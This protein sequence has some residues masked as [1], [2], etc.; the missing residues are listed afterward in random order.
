MRTIHFLGLGGICLILC[1]P[2]I[3]APDDREQ[4]LRDQV[5][6]A[7]SRDKAATA[8]RRYF[9][10]LGRAGL[11]E[12]LTDKDTA[13]ALHAAWEVHKKP[14]K[15]AKLIDNR[16]DHIYDR[17]ELS[18]FVAFLK[19]RTKAP[20]PDWWT[21]AIAEVE[22]FPGRHHGFPWKNTVPK[23]RKTK[24]GLYVPD[25]VKLEEDGGMLVYTAGDR[26][27][28]FQ[29]SAFADGLDDCFLGL[30]G[31]KRSVIAAYSDASGFAFTIAGFE[32]K[33][34]KPTWKAEVWAAGRMIL[35]GQG[36][37]N[38]ELKEK[39]GV[40]FVFG[41]ES[42]GMYL[43]AFDIATGKC[44]YRFCTCYWFNFSEMWDLN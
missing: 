23:L 9:A 6:N 18:K 44:Q 33:G 32:G 17:D 39:D 10:H 15:R 2:A 37:H 29:K 34:G 16:A 22:L 43:E 26:A 42:H 5:L 27:V 19:D 8:Y 11:R 14:V 7:D 12:R 24:T 40:V 3:T 31:E 28:E 21:E 20:V 36:Y 1:S 35:A 38:V 13:I 4:T 30:V 25:G 41:A